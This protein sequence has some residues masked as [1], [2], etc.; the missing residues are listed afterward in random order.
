M[1]LCTNPVSLSQMKKLREHM[2][3]V[4]NQV[5]SVERKMEA[6]KCSKLKVRNL[7]QLMV[8]L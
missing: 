7:S 2:K 1:L 3:C 8:A 6:V 5:Q 4:V